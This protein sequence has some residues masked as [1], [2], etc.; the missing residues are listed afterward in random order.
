[1]LPLLRG[2]DELI[3]ETPLRRGS[4]LRRDLHQSAHIMHTQSPTHGSV[5]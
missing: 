2:E 5:R 4:R 1:M 3:I